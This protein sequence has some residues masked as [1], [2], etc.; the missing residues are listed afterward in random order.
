MNTL[1]M[2]DPFEGDS[3][4]WRYLIVQDTWTSAQARDLV[5][6]VMQAKADLTGMDVTRAFW[7]R[8]GEVALGCSFSWRWDWIC[9]QCGGVWH[10]LGII[11]TTLHELAHSLC[12]TQ[13]ISDTAGPAIA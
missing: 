9:V 13:G 4:F 12:T 10:P 2:Y 11:S 8:R 1:N 5:I 7:T 3:G 6:E